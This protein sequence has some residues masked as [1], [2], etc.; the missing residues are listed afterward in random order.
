MKNEF[1]KLIV[2]DDGI[3]IQEDKLS[4]IFD[5]FKQADGSTTRKYG[6][7]G[8]GLAICKEL[9]DLFEG[10]IEISSQ[11]NIGTTVKVRFPKNFNMVNKEELKVEQNLVKET[12]PTQNKDNSFEDTILFDNSSE[13]SG[14]KKNI[15]IL[16]KDPI[17]Y[18]SL[19]IELTKNYSVSQASNLK[20]FKEK[21]KNEIFD[22]FIVDMQ[23]FTK[24][25]INENFL[26]QETK[27][28]F[29]LFK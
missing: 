22:L 8:L 18:M 14:T 28:Y 17:N 2:S 15:L 7:T 6:G 11:L 19:I 3:G 12:K 24:E 13:I 10:E 23:C 29:C 21:I 27:N 9:I 1:V 4:T 25:Q 26:N 16:H 20:D 5:R